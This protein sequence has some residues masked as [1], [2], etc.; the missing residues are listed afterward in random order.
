[1]FAMLRHVFAKLRP[2]R[3]L[4]CL[5][6]GHGGAVEVLAGGQ[7]QGPLYISTNVMVLKTRS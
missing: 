1:M 6:Q 3:V 7:G 5:H 4:H 2:I